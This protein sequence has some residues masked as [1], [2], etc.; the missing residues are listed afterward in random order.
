[1]VAV[2][3]LASCHEVDD[4]R[5]PFAPVHI[6]FATQAQWEIYGVTGALQ[7]RRFIL[8]KG[9]PSGFPYNVQCYTGFGGVLLCSDVYGNPVAYDLAC[10]VERNKNTLIIVDNDAANAYCP[11][12]HSVYDVFSNFGIP[13]SGEAAQHG[14][15][16]RRYSVTAGINGGYRMVRN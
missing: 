11:V 16:L 15:G 13:L 14:Y 6:P 5:I 12:C 2:L 8:D 4:D 3:I 1:M 9:E 7:H 10:P